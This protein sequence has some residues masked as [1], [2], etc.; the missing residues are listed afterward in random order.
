MWSPTTLVEIAR[1]LEWLPFSFRPRFL[2]AF[3]RGKFPCTHMCGQKRG[4]REEGGKRMTNT[5]FGFWPS[6]SRPLGPFSVARPRGPR[7]GSQVSPLA[8]PRPV[9]PKLQKEG[10]GREVGFMD[11]PSCYARFAA[12]TQRRQ[13]PLNGIGRWTT[14][15]IPSANIICRVDLVVAVWPD[16]VSL[17]DR[18]V[19]AGD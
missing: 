5:S 18:G 6:P 4:E 1:V 7:L 9:C 10:K 13:K 12:P 11:F 3:P 16:N 8:R 2:A 15:S 17:A 14:A 19:V